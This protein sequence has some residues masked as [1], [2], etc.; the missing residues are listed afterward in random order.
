MS[1][2]FAWSAGGLISTTADLDHFFSACS[3][4]GSWS[5]A[6]GTRDGSH[7]VAGQINGDRS[8]LGAFND[9]LEAQFCPATPT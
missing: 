7:M 3:V 5:C 6:T 1:Q 2:T 8:G 9:I 4:A